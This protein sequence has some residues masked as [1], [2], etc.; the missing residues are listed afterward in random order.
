[1]KILPV[2]ITINLILSLLIIG[3]EEWLD[4]ETSN[5]EN[6]KKEYI[7][8]IHKLEK[9]SNINLWIDDIVVSAFIDNSF[10]EEAADKNLI[11]FYNLY[12]EKFNLGISRYIYQGKDTKNIELSYEVSIYEKGKIR[13]LLS[14]KNDKGLLQFKSLRVDNSK[15]SGIFEV[16]QPY[17]KVLDVSK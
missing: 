8:D 11:S 3:Y 5:L 12:K 17:K 10:D 16:A 6:L 14:I 2:I 13:D 1:M 7:N 9:I 4:K 15:I